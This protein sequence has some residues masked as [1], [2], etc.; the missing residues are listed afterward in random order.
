MKYLGRE[1]PFKMDVKTHGAGTGNH[2]FAISP[3]KWTFSQP[4]HGVN[5]DYIVIKF[6]VYLEIYLFYSIKT[7]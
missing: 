7:I 1:C 4:H 5:I 3:R 6:K 2:Y